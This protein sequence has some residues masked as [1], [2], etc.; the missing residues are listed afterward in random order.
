M[1]H[2]L[3]SICRIGSLW[4]IIGNKFLFVLLMIM[5]RVILL[6]RIIMTTDDAIAIREGIIV[7]D[8][9]IC[10]VKGVITV[11]VTVIFNPRW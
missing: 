10:L 9:M 6:K 7:V 1:Q 4:R 2:N 11:K 8:F 5:Y 3:K